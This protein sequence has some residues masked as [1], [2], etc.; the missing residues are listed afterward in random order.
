MLNAMP[1]ETHDLP[2]EASTRVLAE[3]N[4][5]LSV[6]VTAKSQL[7]QVLDR[8]I[9][10]DEATLKHLLKTYRDTLESVPRL[11]AH[12]RSWESLPSV[13]RVP[14]RVSLEALATGI[15]ELRDRALEVINL[16]GEI[17]TRS[18]PKISL[19]A[20]GWGETQPPNP[21]LEIPRGVHVLGLWFVN[22]PDAHPDHPPVG[23]RTRGGGNWLAVAFRR[24]GRW[25]LS[26]RFRYFAREGE[27]LRQ[28]FDS[29]APNAGDAL[30]RDVTLIA[31]T[32]ASRAGTRAEFLDVSGGT[33]ELR[34]ALER[35][36]PD[37]SRFIDVRW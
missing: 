15:P 30:K 31:Q 28:W 37:W 4:D 1:P 29:P 33:R 32:L 5:A 21:A 14:Y 27:D 2:L 34:M 16:V 13:Q 24:D 8:G 18:A 23:F 19:P 9:K 17:A 20:E 22:L 7:E 6:M 11:E 26:L 35:S 3:V 25:L 10:P 12:L 36:K